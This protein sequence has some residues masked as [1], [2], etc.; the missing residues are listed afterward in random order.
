VQRSGV[1]I[2]AGPPNSLEWSQRLCSFQLTEPS[3]FSRQDEIDALS[4]YEGSGPTR[5]EESNDEP[6]LLAANCESR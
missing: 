1:Q 2:P 5:M 4:K 6:N 3:Q